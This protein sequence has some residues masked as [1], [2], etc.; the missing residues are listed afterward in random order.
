M[1]IDVESERD[2]T[3]G[4]RDAHHLNAAGAALPS[5]RTLAA[6]LEHLHLESRMGGYEASNAVRPRLDAVYALA[7]S[8][9]GAHP[10]EIALTESATVGWQRA[11]DALRLGRGDR[12]LVSRSG[13]VSCA[14]QL[15]ALERDRGIVVELLP[16]GEDGALDLD[17]LA[18]ALAAGPAALLALTHIPTS[19]GLVEPVVEAGRLAN[20]AGVTYLLDATQSVGHLPVDVREIGC[21]VL[22][23]TGRKY[24]RGPRGT[25]LLY[26]RRSTLERLEPLSPDVRGATWTADRAWSLDDTARRY[27]TWEAAHALRLGLGVALA[28]AQALGVDAISA[29]LVRRGA[30]L[31]GALAEIPGVTIADPP[32][33]RGALVT[34]LVEGTE[35]R[36]VASALAERAVQLVSVPA[37]HGRWDLAGRDLA[38]IVRAAPHVY[39]SDAD[40][41]ALVDGVAQIARPGRPRPN[42]RHTGPPGPPVERA[43]VVVVGLGAHGSAAAR[44]LAERGLKVIGLE[45]L[46]LGHDRGSSHGESRMIRRAYARPVWDDLVDRAYGAWSRLEEAA[47]EQL[48]IPT[49]GV[50]ARPV[51]ATDALRGPGCE[52]LGRDAVRAIFPAVH[53]GDDLEGLYDPAAG[54]LLAE[55]AVA[56]QQRLA[57][58]A[59]AALREAEPLVSWAPDG[60]GVVLETVRGRIA[61]DRL[62]VCA[63]AWIPQVLPGLGLQQRVAR[64]VNVLLRPIDAAAVTLPT[65]GVFA[66]ELPFGLVYGVGAIGE[67]GLKIGL[68]DGMEIDPD[69]PRLPA[70]PD[71]IAQ[72]VG[73]VQRHL[74]AAAGD[75]LSTLTC[76]YA[77]TPDRRFVVGELPGTPQVLACSACSG[78]GFKFAPALGEAL[79]DLVA[80]AARPDLDFIAP[81]RLLGIAR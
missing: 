32:A 55:R 27:E 68:D 41:D 71:E 2:R 11:V 42:G 53:L 10:D 22:V 23:T 80:G 67:A 79:S 64:I 30:E 1:L 65:L 45:R 7:A 3:P 20:A 25:A 51:G 24:L 31:R 77:V 52:V 56:A 15:L 19:S 57:R 9:I 74:P 43:D 75:V 47:G 35:P 34:F 8:L 5:A 13:Y 61:A 59:G 44:S 16:N 39:T 33:A 14:L 29:H 48:L 66:F 36:D 58:Q 69:A 60:E 28:E 37:G 62:V 50:F 73:V 63:G 78:H 81:A 12:V 46:R 70:Q 26:V 76:M 4:V 49:G 38:A 21:D 54:A 6:T 17:A 40:L 18:A 72:L